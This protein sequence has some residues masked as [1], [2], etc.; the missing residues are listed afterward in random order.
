M[1][2]QCH[3]RVIMEKDGRKILSCESCGYIHVFP[4]YNEAELEQFY[5]DIYSESTPS[6]LMFEKVYNIKKW[7]EKG[8]V[9]D[10]GCWEGYQLEF[11]MDEGW[12]CVG[13]ELNSRAASVA[14][15]KGIKV[16]QISINQFFDK[17]AGK[18]WDVINVAYILE[19]IPDPADF[20]S[21]IRK[22]LRDDGIIIVEVPN[23]FSPF[24]LAYIKEH[25]MQPYWIALPD[26]LNYFDKQSIKYLMERTGWRIIHAE[27]SFPMEMFLLMGDNYLMDRSIGKHSFK[28]VVEMERILRNYDPGLVSRMYSE[29]YKCGVGRSIILYAKVKEM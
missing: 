12:S 26:H 25:N 22:H 7:K 10:I 20:L 16:H 3:G 17:F 14:A 8:T 18:K 4:R 2:R 11:F 27:T 19:H 28:K 23:E 21:R 13:L 9:L 6:Y 24:Q 1:N 29:L 15:S 5:K